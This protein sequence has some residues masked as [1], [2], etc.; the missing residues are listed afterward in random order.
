[1]ASD[2]GKARE[3]ASPVQLLNNEWFPPGLLFIGFGALGLFLSRNYD[4]GD[5]NHMGPGWFPRA[6]CIG[7]I[8]LGFVICWRGLFERSAA[9]S[10]GRVARGFVMILLSM[11]AFG[12]AIERLGFVLAL[13]VVVLV[14]S[15]AHREQKLKE[16]LLTMILVVATSLAV[17]VYAL[18]LPFRL[19]PDV[20]LL[21]SYLPGS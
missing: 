11:A 2:A 16:V 20:A 8:G 4:M 6:L 15:L 21:A 18:K 17:F 12:F 5:V 1:M 7:L 19:W 10:D 9:N 3:R 14:S 13:C